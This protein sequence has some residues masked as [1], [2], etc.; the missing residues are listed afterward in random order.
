MDNTT[1]VAISS[2]LGEAGIGVIRL[3]GPDSLAIAKKLTA[4]SD[5]KDRYMHYCKIEDIDE[6]LVCYMKAPHTYTGEDVVEI[7]CHGS[8]AS[9]K[10]ILTRCLELGA[11]MAEPGEFTKRAFLNGRLDLSQAE[12]VIDLIK[13]KTEK[14][15]ASANTQLAGSLG[16]K[17]KEIRND[18]KELLINLTVNMDY[19]DEDIEEI[20][21]KNIEENLLNVKTRLEILLN[22]SNEGRVLREGLGVAIIGKPNVGKSSL[23]NIFMGEER[24]IVTSVAGTTRDTIEETAQIRGIPVRITDTAGIHESDDVVEKIGIEKSR[25]AFNK[26]DLVLLVLD[27][28]KEFSLEDKE[29]LDASVNTDTIVLVNKSDLDKKINF[30]TNLKTI[31]TSFKNGLGVEELKDAIEEFVT[32]GSAERR[33]TPALSNIRHIDLV[34]KALAEI[35][36]ALNMTLAKE[37]MDFIEI[38]VNAAFMYLGEITGDTASGEVIDAIFSRFCLGK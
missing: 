37:A 10:N 36:E 7:Q 25:D 27:G 21:Y 17:I 38:N 20:T 14:S 15:L 32:K 8:S 12:A 34:K 24:S 9:L 2:A 29:L 3:S 13:A 33:E 11:S 1:I 31:Y 16:N 4:K 19:P 30:E 26:A 6:A 23:M 22:Q 18:L 5:F 28:S 35:G